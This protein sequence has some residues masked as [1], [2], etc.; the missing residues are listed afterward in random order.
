MQ[1]HVSVIIPTKNGLPLFQKCLDGVLNQ[2][3]PWP[4][5]VIVVDSGS[6]DGTWELAL[7]RATK[8]IRIAPDEFNHGTT[9]NL[10]ATYSRG[11]Y[12]VFLVQ[13]AVPFDEH[14]LERLVTSCEAESVAGSF[15]CQ[16]VRRDSDPITHYLCHDALPSGSSREVKRLAAQ[17]SLNE[18]A[19][20]ERY[21]ISRF[22]NPSSCVRRDVFQRYPFACLPYGEDHEWGKRVIEAGYSIV[23]EPSSRV[24]HSH[25]RSPIYALKRAYADHF[26]AADLFEYVM[27][28]TFGQAVRAV[29]GY[30]LSSWMYAIRDI[31]GFT[32]KIK[33][34]IC[35]PAHIAGLTAGQYLGPK[36]RTWLVK[37]AWLSRIDRRLRRGV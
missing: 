34:T 21:E 31:D 20:A 27:I 2:V 22:Q 37:S 7:N 5:E 12:L 16:M 29:A 14:W 9:R 23:Y 19:P 25:D 15:S 13:D 10:A 36:M 11:K 8:A 28:P 33:F 3:A 26:Q 24:Y 17:R 4:F 30:T 35:I 6:R 32:A 1:P 18:L